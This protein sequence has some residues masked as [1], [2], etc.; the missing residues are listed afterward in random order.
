[1][2]KNKISAILFYAAALIFFVTAFIEFIGKN[3]KDSMGVVFLCL[4]AAMLCT[5]SANMKQYKKAADDSENKSENKQ[6]NHD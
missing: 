2:D 3:S 1:M 5:G 4:G 6:E